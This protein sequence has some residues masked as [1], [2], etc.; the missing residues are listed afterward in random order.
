VLGEVARYIE[1]KGRAGLG[2]V[3]L[4]SNKWI[5]VQRFGEQYR[6]YVVVNCRSS[7]TST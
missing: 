3:A 6:L 5:K 2:D 1:V 7:R 4:T